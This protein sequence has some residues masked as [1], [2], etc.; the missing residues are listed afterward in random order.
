MKNTKFTKIAILI[1]SVALLVGAAFAVSTSAT[2][3]PSEEEILSDMKVNLK[4]GDMLYFLCLVDAE[5]LGADA[6][7]SFTLY[8]DADCTDMAATVKAERLEEGNEKLG[9]SGYTAAYYADFA[10]FGVSATFMGVDYYVVATN[11]TSET[12]GDPV[13]CSVVKYLLERLYEDNPT[14]IQREH[15]E[16][17]IAYG[18]TAQKVTKDEKTNVADYCYVG[19]TGGEVLVD[20]VSVGSS[21]ILTKGATVTL[22]T[23]EA[24]PSGNI[25]LWKDAAGNS[26]KGAEKITVSSSGIYGYTALPMLTFD[27]MNDATVTISSSS[28]SFTTFGDEYAAY[29]KAFRIYNG[30]STKNP[31]A[32]SIVNEKLVI[33]SD[34]GSDYI[35]FFPTY[36][37]E[38]YNHV[39]FEA[40]LTINGT[41]S[42]YPVLYESNASSK[43]FAMKTLSYNAS[44]GVFKFNP[45]NAS[46]SSGS[47]IQTTLPTEGE[48]AHTVNLKIDLYDLDGDVLILFYLNGTLSY[49]CD[50][51]L[52]T[53]AN[54]T[55]NFNYTNTDGVPMSAYY[56]TYNINAEG[57]ET[58]FTQFSVL[59][60]NTD[61][62]FSGTISIDNVMFM[63]TKTN[64]IPDVNTTRK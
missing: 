28:S 35:R 53:D 8:K 45:T 42:M 52:V 6:D 13:K 22:K 36:T 54:V 59:N 19:A 40:D 24:L 60:I 43:V 47:T 50:S 33:N 51:R 64:E 38:G 9:N 27:G 48:N 55:S 7:V 29:N 62:G 56:G 12:S 30:T 39:T 4:Y 31:P 46:G 61:G 10:S 41:G 49:I 25:A 23:T 34:D 3:S 17:T 5:N 21:A 14:D 37:E 20:G 2:E 1:L 11:N 44:T 32:S 15:Y 58:P 26:Y 63:Q 18:S 16:N 57:K